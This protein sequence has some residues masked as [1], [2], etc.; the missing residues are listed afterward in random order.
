MKRYEQ[1]Y[2]RKET[3]VDTIQMRKFQLFGHICRMP[4][5]GLLKHYCLEWSRVSVVREELDEDGF[6]TLLMVRKNFKRLDADDF[7][8]IYKTYVRPHMEYCIQAWSPHL[9]KDIQILESVQRTATRMVSTLK[10]LPYESRLHR[11]SLGL[12]MIERRRIRG[13]LIETFKILTGIEKVDMEQFFELS[14]TGYN[15]RGHSK[16]LTVNRCRLDS[17]KYFFSNRVVHHWNKLMQEIVQA[18]SVNVFKNRLD[19]H[20]QDMGI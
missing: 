1:L 3:V 14:D 5:D 20:W 11:L 19:R 17:R 13:D 10:K 7:I 18:Q 15:L 9:V 2:K 16:R 6:M 12:T 4:D 8:L